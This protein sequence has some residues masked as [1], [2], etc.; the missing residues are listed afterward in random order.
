MIS[1]ARLLP[2]LLALSLMLGGCGAAMKQR[3]EACKTGDWTQI[4]RTDGLDGAPPTFADRK[5]FCDD[6]ADAKS[7][8]AVDAAARYTAG[9]AQGNWD[10]WYALGGK[11][12]QAGLQPSQYDRHAASDEVRKHQTPLNRPAYDAGWT[13]GNSEYW[14]DI[15]KREGTS[16]LPLSQKEANRG[17]AAASQLRFDE[18]AYADGW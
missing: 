11:D 7:P 14:R 18:A 2:L 9:W 6:H 13:F 16:G 1:L 3:I 17:K 15:G 5:D 8:A 4:G 12:G 10:L